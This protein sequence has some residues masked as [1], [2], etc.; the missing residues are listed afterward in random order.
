VVVVV[1]PLDEPLGRSAAQADNAA[2]TF[3]F[4]ASKPLAPDAPAAPLEL[5]RPVGKVTPWSFKQ[6]L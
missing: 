4:E 6:L 3:G 2:F 1:L 5:G